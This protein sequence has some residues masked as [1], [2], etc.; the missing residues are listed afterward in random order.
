MLSIADEV[1]KED[2]IIAWARPHP[3]DADALNDSV[4]RPTNWQLVSTR[5]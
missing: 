3:R 5:D 4:G 2:H 1:S